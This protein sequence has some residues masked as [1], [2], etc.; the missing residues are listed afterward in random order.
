M[1]GVFVQLLKNEDGYTVVEWGILGL[2]AVIFA[3]RLTLG[4]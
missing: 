1:F 3:E 4:F 2:L